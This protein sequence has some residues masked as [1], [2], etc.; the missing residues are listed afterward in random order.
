MYSLNFPDMFSS[1]NI[2]LA[3]DRDATMNNLKLSLLSFKGELFGDPYFGSNLATIIYKSNDEIIKDVVIDDIYDTV[4]MFVPQVILPR[5]NIN[6]TADKTHLYA[7][8]N[9]TNSLNYV[10]DMYNIELTES[11]S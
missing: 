6:L 5:K 7:T 9:A 3:K 8:L 10:T 4:A 2:K 1:S 11:E